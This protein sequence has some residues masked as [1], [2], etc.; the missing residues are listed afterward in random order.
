MLSIADHMH[1]L[2][3]RFPKCGPN[4]A[5]S[6][7][8]QAI[9]DLCNEHSWSFLLKD[10]KIQTEALYNTG[11]IAVLNGSQAVTLSVDGTW[12]T[13]W[14]TT[15]STRK[16][17]IAGR[18]E[19][20]NL[21]VTGANTGTLDSN[22]LG[23]DNATAS[24]TLYRDT[25]PLPVDCDFGREYFLLDP[26][27]NRDVKLIEFGTFHRAFSMMQNV[28]GLPWAA[29][30][31]GLTTVGATVG[32]PQLKFGPQPPS[33]AETYALLYFQKPVKPT[34]LTDYPSPLWPER[35]E[36]L[37]YRRAR[38]QYAEDH[39]LANVNRLRDTYSSRFFDVQSEFNGKNEMT[40]RIR[41]T[42]PSIF[43][44]GDQYLGDPQWFVGSY[45]K[46]TYP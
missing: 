1:K 4:E 42:L 43:F 12:L 2:R 33:S 8:W 40:R 3:S 14:T 25:Y 9:I 10:G 29:C 23:D 44:E 20:Y 27:R 21:T 30:R 34:A 26:A 36:D 46:A 22:W 32:V 28:P 45:P 17:M 38:W 13:S 11:T 19:A 35:G 41:N 7:T 15:P 31:V 37:I 39:D 24:Y 16:I 18:A 6:Y 5:E